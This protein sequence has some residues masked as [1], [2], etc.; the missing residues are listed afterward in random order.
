MIGRPQQTTTARNSF[1]DPAPA[2][3]DGLTNE[4]FSVNRALP[5]KDALSDAESY[6]RRALQVW[7]IALLTLPLDVLLVLYELPLPTGFLE[8]NLTD[9][10]MIIAFV[11]GLMGLGREWILDGIMLLR[12]K[13]DSLLSKPNSWYVWLLA[14]LLAGGGL[15]ELLARTGIAGLL[16]LLLSV[17]VFAIW[18]FSTYHDVRKQLLE[19]AAL[20]KNKILWAE[21][22]NAYIFNIVIVPIVLIRLLSFL[23]VLKS[24]LSG[25]I[26]F[27]FIPYFAA[28]F[29]IL[30]ALIPTREL[31]IICCQR[32]SNWTSRALKYS[33][34]CPACAREFFGVHEEGQGTLPS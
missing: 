34:Y 26:V 27:D 22:V 6:F 32:C 18:V 23:A 7:R 31:F 15:L 21:N 30:L 4:K 20:D 25:S 11:V 17:I 9:Q 24:S 28:S 19:K 14:A 2:A 13:H 8:S 10:A 12:H 5:V 33:G 29:F 1:Q 3:K 16:S